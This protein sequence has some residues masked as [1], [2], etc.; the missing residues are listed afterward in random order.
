[1]K[2]ATREPVDLRCLDFPGPIG[3]GS[4]VHR[5]LW[6]VKHRDRSGVCRAFVPE[7]TISRSSLFG[8]KN[9]NDQDMN[10]CLMM[11]L[12]ERRKHLYSANPR[13]KNIRMRR[14]AVP[15]PE[16]GIVDPHPRR[17]RLDSLQVR[18]YLFDDESHGKAEAFV[19]RQSMRPNIRTRRTRKAVALLEDGIVDSHPRPRR[20]QVRGLH[21]SSTFARRQ[22]KTSFLSRIKV[23]AE[24]HVGCDRISDRDD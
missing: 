10:I 11:N 18:G 4:T 8:N 24:Q 16:D 21:H 23:L 1:M 7:R 2:D 15:L 12:M 19:Q 9:K 5:R 14:K 17:R 20:L 3:D 13:G 22:P 6:S